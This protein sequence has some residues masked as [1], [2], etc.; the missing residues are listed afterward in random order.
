MATVN[1]WYP[2]I[3]DPAAIIRDRVDKSN[4]NTMA[5]SFV[6]NVGHA[7]LTLDN[8]HPSDYVSWWPDKKHKSFSTP[9]F[10][11]DVK[12]EGG[13]PSATVKLDFLND[14]LIRMWWKRVKLDG[15]AFPYRLEFLPQDD[16]WTL[17]RNNCSHMVWLALKVGGAEKYGAL[18]TWGATLVTPPQ[19]HAYVLRIKLA[20]AVGKFFEDK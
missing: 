7:S 5:Y 1:V 19:I 11:Q 13:P 2:T 12:L 8:T 9:T 15:R 4:A 14:D 3:K 16:K 10:A 6:E 20:A 18:V 17:D